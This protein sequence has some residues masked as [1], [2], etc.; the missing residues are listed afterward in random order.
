MTR[1]VVWHRLGLYPLSNDHSDFF[2]MLL[3]GDTCHYRTNDAWGRVG[4][5]VRVRVWE[6]LSR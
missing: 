2:V 4:Q 3:D 5:R 1:N 6:R